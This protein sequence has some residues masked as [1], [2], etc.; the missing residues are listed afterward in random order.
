M[1]QIENK[2]IS[3]DIFEQY[4][5]CNLSVCKG[6]CCVEGQSGA[7]LE[8]EETIILEKIFP[9]IK[10]FLHES[11]QKI[12]SEKG[13]WE[14]DFENDKVTPLINGNECVY[15]YYDDEICKCAIEKAYNERLIDFKKPISCHLYPIRISK[16]QHFEAFNYHSWYVCKPCKEAAKNKNIP[17][18]QFLKEPIIR[19]Y[20]K[21]FFTEMEKVANVVLNLK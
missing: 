17:L 6:Y 18:Y 13:T 15:V 12:I 5:C 3:L 16:Y 10:P 19:K 2:I 7:P 14:T 21:E 20:G 4:F 9:V 11:A 1:I 8:D